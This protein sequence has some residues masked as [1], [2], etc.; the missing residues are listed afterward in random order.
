MFDSLEVLRMAQAFATHAGTRQQAIA[1][2]IAN[3]DTPGYQARDAIA[4]SDYFQRL[5]DRSGAGRLPQNPNAFFRTDADP[6]SRAPNG[7]TVSLEY[8]MMRGVE[9]RQQHELALGIY[10][11][12]RDLLRSSLGK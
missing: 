4:F 2:N 5:D 8:E 10:S 9:T 3:A 6:V 11:M 12:A 7:N 1:Q